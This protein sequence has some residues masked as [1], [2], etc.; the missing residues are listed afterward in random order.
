MKK[1]CTYCN[2]TYLPRPQVKNPKACKK[3]RC[4]KLRQRD[5]ERSWHQKN[6][7]IYDSKYA[8]I[9][10]EIRKVKI[11][12]MIQTIINALAIGLRF[13]GHD[14]NENFKNLTLF[15]SELGIRQLNKFCIDLSP[16]L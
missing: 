9:Q 10:R 3:N 14:F 8:R 5:N 4:Q 1:T 15:L 16:P 13:N 12:K 11:K 7:D 6:R 2:C